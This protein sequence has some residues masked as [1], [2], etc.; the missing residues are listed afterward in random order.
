MGV[1]NMV[2]EFCYETI[3][4]ALI[5]IEENDRDTW[6]DFVDDI[7][8]L[9]YFSSEEYVKDQ[10]RYIERELF[11]KGD[12]VEATAEMGNILMAALWDDVIFPIWGHEYMKPVI[13]DMITDKKERAGFM[14]KARKAWNNYY[15][16]DERRTS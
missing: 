9:Q 1:G 14:S 15:G 4:P 12:L 3:S 2:L 7:L 10:A 11:E 16:K 5:K 8:D 13:E 6:L